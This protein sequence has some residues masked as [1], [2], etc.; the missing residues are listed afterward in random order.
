M[1][2]KSVKNKILIIDDEEINLELISSILN[3]NYIVYSE[4]NA[5]KSIKKAIHKKP[6]IILL[7]IVM[8]FIDGFKICNELKANAATTDI[9]IIFLTSKYKEEDQE[10]FPILLKFLWVLSQY[11]RK[12]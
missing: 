11:L 1:S 6:D 5:K 8:P 12:V 3:D 9:P 2:L 10:R 4:K 7:D